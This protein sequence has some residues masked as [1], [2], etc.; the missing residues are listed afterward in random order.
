MRG[1]NAHCRFVFLL[2]F[3]VPSFPPT[4]PVGTLLHCLS[5]TSSPA[6]SLSFLLL[7][8]VSSIAGSFPRAFC[9]SCWSPCLDLASLLPH[10]CSCPSL[11]S[12]A[13]CS[14]K[15]SRLLPSSDTPENLPQACSPPR[16]QSLCQKRKGWGVCFWNPPGCSW[17]RPRPRWYFLGQSPPQLLCL[18]QL[19]AHTG[20]SCSQPASAPEGRPR[21]R[22]ER[23]TKRKE[24][25]QWLGCWGGDN[26]RGAGGHRWWARWDQHKRAERATDRPGLV[27]RTRRR[28]GSQGQQSFP[29]S[30]A[31]EHHGEACVA[32]RL[33]ELPI[34]KT[35]GCD[36]SACSALG[37]SAGFCQEAKES[38]HPGD[39][40]A[41]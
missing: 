1:T 35:R 32:L 5:V 30:L 15:W 8:P 13:P 11:G 28:V 16:Q 12:V 14:P 23:R 36:I 24:E 10:G 4:L 27:G 6:P 9:F 40:G 39:L 25:E 22:Q 20:H 7:L 26:N 34:Q 21:T 19:R 31:Q 29:R 18:K 2:W 41:G 3:F 38:D 17:Q 33:E 37:P